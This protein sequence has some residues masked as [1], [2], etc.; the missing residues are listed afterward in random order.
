MN[1]IILGVVASLITAFLIGFGK[2]A[3]SKAILR[4][5]KD[6]FGL[7]LFRS[8][9]LHLVYAQLS[10]LPLYDEQGLVPPYPYVKPGEERS[11]IGFSVENPVS[12]CELRAAKYLAEM[13]GRV[14]KKSPLLSSDIELRNS[15]DISFVSFG[16][17]SSNYKT[18]DMLANDANRLLTFGVETFTATLSGRAVHIRQSGFD[19]GL[20]MKIFPTQFPNRI[21][22]ICAGFAEWGTSATAWY[23]AHKWREIQKFAKKDHFA[24]V[25]KVRPGQ[26]ESAEPVAWIK[27]PAD[28]ESYADSIS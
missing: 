2:L 21:W 25:V 3:Y 19:Y 27:S 18:R 9:G 10:L 22:I 7:D 1:D 15:L 8:D 11:G 26:D 5:F 4:K 16:G 14:A 17:G 24:I 6:V 28:A 23:L 12:S 20:I 13:M